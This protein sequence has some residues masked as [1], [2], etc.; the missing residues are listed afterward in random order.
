MYDL[1]CY[2]R[3][4]LYI[5]IYVCVCIYNNLFNNNLLGGYIP[6]TIFSG[7]D[8]STPSPLKFRPC[9]TLQSKLINVTT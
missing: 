3:C 6:P 1:L 9:N 5:Y 2:L 7:G 4:I 8:T